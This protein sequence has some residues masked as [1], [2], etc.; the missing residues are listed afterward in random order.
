MQPALTSDTEDLGVNLLRGQLKLFPQ[1]SAVEAAS[2]GF[3]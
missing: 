2:F 1:N 3:P